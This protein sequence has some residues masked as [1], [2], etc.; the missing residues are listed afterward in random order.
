[1]IRKPMFLRA[2]VLIAFLFTTGCQGLFKPRT[3]PP[4]APVVVSNGEPPPAGTSSS[5]GVVHVP[6]F[7]SVKAPRVGVIFGPGGAKVLAQVGALQ[8]LERQKIPVVAAV[9]LEWG[10]LIGAL[11]SLNGQSHEVD[12]KMSQLPK[13]NFSASN[14]FSKKMQATTAAEYNKYLSKIFA[15]ERMESTKVPFACSYIKKESSRAGLITKGVVRN[16]IKTCWQ[17]PPLF[18]VSD[19]KAAPYAL[20]DAVTYLKKQGAEL[21]LLINVLENPS[22]KD[23]A[24]WDNADWVWFSWVP[25]HVA[26]RSASGFGVNETINIDTSAFSM[27]DF[28]QRL[29]LIQVGKQGAASQIDRL[30]KKYDF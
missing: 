20:A 26:L 9:G 28:E 4:D 2:L 25:V 7:V 8:E 11:Y 1:V 24:A 29:R 17:Y 3:T 15:G 30:I 18:S 14:I 27:T 10:A 19:S 21:I 23:F 5:G 16:V 6:D 22:Q 13:V 12:W